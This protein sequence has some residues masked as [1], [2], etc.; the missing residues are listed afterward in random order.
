[1]EMFA[2]PNAGLGFYAKFEQEKMHFS[3][4]LVAIMVTGFVGLF[5]NRLLEKVETF[6]RQRWGA[7]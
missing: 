2:G 7:D 4:L 6:T 1:M 5:L 3:E